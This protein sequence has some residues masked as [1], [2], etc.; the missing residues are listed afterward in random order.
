LGRSAGAF[1]ALDWSDKPAEA[2]DRLANISQTVYS[3][4]LKP[5]Q[6]GCTIL[7][8]YN[9]LGENGILRH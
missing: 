7:L 1:R 2:I 5:K 3:A 6:K 9:V 4:S 8:P